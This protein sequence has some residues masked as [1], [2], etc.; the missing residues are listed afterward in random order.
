M[1]PVTEVFVRAAR[2]EQQ[3]EQLR[4]ELGLLR[5][6][7]ERLQAAPGE[8]GAG[9]SAD[10]LLAALTLAQDLGADFRSDDPHSLA[11]RGDDWMD[12]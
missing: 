4:Q 2:L 6:D 12:P 5:K 1:G 3:L 8:P 10:C 9:E 11:G 7:L